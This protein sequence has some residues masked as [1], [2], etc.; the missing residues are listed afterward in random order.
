M[1]LKW[2]KQ[3]AEILA[4]LFLV[5]G[6]IISV[7]LQSALI[8]YISIAVAG[9]LAGRI[10]YIKRYKEPILPFVLIILGFLV[11]YLIGSI[12]INRIVV[13]LLFAIMFWGSYYVHVHKIMTVY[14]QEPFV[15]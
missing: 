12:W 15:R 1:D 3:W 9:F 2:S 5:L 13:L 6:F 11:G 8:S 14:K 4:L 10:Y 7:L